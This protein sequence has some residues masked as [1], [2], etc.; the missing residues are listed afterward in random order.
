MKTGLPLVTPATIE[1]RI[2][3]NEYFVVNRQN[4]M[5][6]R[7]ATAFASRFHSRVVAT[8]DG[9]SVQ[10]MAVVHSLRALELHFWRRFDRDTNRIQ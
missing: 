4:V 3:W 10:V 5:Q 6:I 1:V 7:L 9:N 2:K 8:G